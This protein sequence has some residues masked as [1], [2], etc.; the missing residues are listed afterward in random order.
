MFRLDRIKGMQEIGPFK[1]EKGQ[2]LRDFYAS[3]DRGGLG[4]DTGVP[5]ARVGASGG[6]I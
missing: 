1:I 2:T 4:P 3:E 6:D 5:K